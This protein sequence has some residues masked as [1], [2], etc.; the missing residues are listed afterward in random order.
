MHPIN[1]MLT[2]KKI[3]GG[4]LN[5]ANILIFMHTHCCDNKQTLNQLLR[6]NGK[7]K[8][9]RTNVSLSK[10]YILSLIFQR[11][12]RKINCNNIIISGINALV[13]I[14]VSYVDF[15]ESKRKSE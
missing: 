3:N 12:A 10:S 6:F 13:G 9:K 8:H 4:D 5:E 15:I 2:K 14:L 11:F 1:L 7:Q